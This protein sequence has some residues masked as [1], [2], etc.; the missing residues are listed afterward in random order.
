MANINDLVSLLADVSRKNYVDTIVEA[1]LLG[2]NPTSLTVPVPARIGDIVTEMVDGIESAIEITAENVTK[3]KVPMRKH[4]VT[5]QIGNVQ[6]QDLVLEN[7][8]PE[9]LAAHIGAKVMI[10]IRETTLEKDY[11][12]SGG[13]EHKA[14][15]KF[16]HIAKV[17][18][19]REQF[20]FMALLQQLA[21]VG[22]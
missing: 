1:T 22:K 3:Y 15:E 6:K 18:L 16:V 14:G 11:T 5:V 8:I 7:S 21:K 12:T 10:T 4:S 20:D 13:K 17:A 19:V 2:T 9:N